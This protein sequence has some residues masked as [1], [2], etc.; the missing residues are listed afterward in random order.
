MSSPKYLLLVLCLG[1]SSLFTTTLTAQDL[2]ILRSG[3]TLKGSVEKIGGMGIRYFPEGENRKRPRRVSAMKVELIIY[4]SGMKHYFLTQES[5]IVPSAN[6]LVRP[7]SSFAEVTP[8]NEAYW[9]EKA[10][11]DAADH[12]NRKGPLVG[13]ALATALYPGGG[14]LTGVVVGGAVVAVPPT[15]RPEDIANQELYLNNPTYAESYRLAAHGIKA[16]NVL[17]GF[18]I[19]MLGQA[20]WILL[21]I[22]TF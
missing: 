6:P 5:I 1:L 22:A 4:E 10:K 15:L 3:E 18:G 16:R 12:Y 14:I 17:K 8:S 2:I 7:D 19:G 11:L 20:L 9:K 21:I 13:T